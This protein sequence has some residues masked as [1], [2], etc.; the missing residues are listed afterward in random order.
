MIVFYGGFPT[1]PEISDDNHGDNPLHIFEYNMF[2]D[3]QLRSDLILPQEQHLLWLEYNDELNRGR[4][5]VDMDFDLWVDIKYH[6]REG[7]N[8]HPFIM[9]DKPLTEIELY[10]RDVERL[11]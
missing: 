10:M 5:V 8:Q 6:G 1:V 4:I 3:R 11:A 9:P 2:G 7:A